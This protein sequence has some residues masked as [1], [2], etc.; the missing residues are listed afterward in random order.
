MIIRVFRAVVQPGQQPE[1][2]RF[3]LTK[4]LPRLQAQPGVLSVTVGK[5]LTATETEFLMITVWHD[6]AALQGFAG[7]HWQNAV[8]DPA[9]A[10]LLK[11]TFVHHYAAASD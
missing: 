10:H 3:F 11:E 2:E 7:E 4:A 5:P 8:I 6:L 9:E 1:F